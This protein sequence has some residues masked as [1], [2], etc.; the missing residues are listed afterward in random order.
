LQDQLAADAELSLDLVKVHM[1]CQ[2]TTSFGQQLKV[3]GGAPELGEWDLNRVS[4]SS[5]PLGSYKLRQLCLFRQ[6]RCLQESEQ[7][8]VLTWRVLL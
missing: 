6:Q 7:L 2:Y 5:L 3:V 4:S 1:K 8:H